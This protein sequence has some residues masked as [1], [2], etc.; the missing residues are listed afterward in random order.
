MASNRTIDVSGMQQVVQ[1]VGERTICCANL[2]LLKFPTLHLHFFLKLVPYPVM[3]IGGAK[4]TTRVR[5]HFQN[6]SGYMIADVE[7]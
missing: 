2:D 5:L 6:V 1:Q 7:T 3:I 4:T